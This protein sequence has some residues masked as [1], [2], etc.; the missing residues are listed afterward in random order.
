MNIPLTGFGI[1]GLSGQLL[2]FFESNSIVTFI[3]FVVGIYILYKLVKLAFRIL[4]AVI[5]GI[6]FPF[7][8]NHFFD[9]GI[10]IT[11]DNLIF[12]ATSA[13]TLYLVAI[14]VLGAVKFLEKFFKPFLEKHKIKKIEKEVE[15]DLLGTKKKRK[16]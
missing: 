2:T 5:A 8:M 14:F 3:I 11:L 16:H 12:Y 6:L 7:V 4:I 10:P 15:K 1:I 13:V 9:W